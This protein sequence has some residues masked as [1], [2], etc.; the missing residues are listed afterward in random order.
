MGT[1]TQGPVG[2]DSSDLDALAKGTAVNS[3][4]PGPIG[5][6]GADELSGNKKITKVTKDW[7]DP[8]AVKTTFTEVSGKTLKEVLTAL[9]KLPEWGTGGGNVTGTGTDG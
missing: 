6:D 2:L 3:A 9:Q 5:I 7:T 4:I 8:P 1:R